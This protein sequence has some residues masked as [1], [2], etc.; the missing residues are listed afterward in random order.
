MPDAILT[1]DGAVNG[2]LDYQ[3]P[4]GAEAIPRNVSATFTDPTNAGPYVPALE[5]VTPDG[6]IVGPFPLGAT[7]AAGASARSSWFRGVAPFIPVPGTGVPPAGNLDG[8]IFK[9]SNV[10]VAGLSHSDRTTLLI[11]GNP[12]TL[13]GSTSIL[14]EYFCSWVEINAGVT[15]Q[16]AEVELWDNFA[17]A[18]HD[19]GTIGVFEFFPNSV[20][21]SAMYASIP[22]TPAAGVHTYSL[23]AWKNVN[24]STVTFVANTLLDGSGNVAPMWYRIL[25]IPFDPTLPS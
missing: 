19:K 25:V 15:N 9:K 8:Y 14:V 11:Q 10:T 20:G 6:H 23:Y 21:G 22:L 5:V 3:V 2:P 1:R 12:V 4:N 18:N 16:A 17:A 7:I 13:D 24:A